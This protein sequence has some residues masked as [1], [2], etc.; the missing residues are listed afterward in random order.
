MDIRDIKDPGFLK[1]LSYK[2]MEELADQIRAFI[3]SEVSKTGG[4]LSSN[5]GVVELTIALHYVFNSPDDKLVFDVGHQTYTHKILTGRANGFDNLRQFGGLAGFEKRSESIHDVWEAG[6]S[7]TSLSGA[8]GMAVARDLKK[9]DHEVVAVIGDGSLFNGESMEALDHIAT[10]KSKVIIVLNDNSMSINR[11]DGAFYKTLSAIRTSYGYIDFKNMVA[12][13]LNNTETGSEVLKG[14]RQAR[15]SMRK[16]LAPDTIFKQ[17]GLD[18]LGPINGHDIE[19]LIKSFQMARRHK[20]SIVIHVITQKGKGYRFSENDEEGYWHGVGCF[21][22]VTGQSTTMIPDGCSTYSAVVAEKALTMADADPMICAITPAMINGSK[23]HKFH[24]RYPQRCFDCGIAEEH[25]ATFAAGLAISG[26][27]PMLFVYSSFMQRCYDQINH[28]ICRMDLPVLLLLDRAGLVGKDGATHHGVFDI[29]ILAPLPNIIL[30]MPAT[31]SEAR[32]L[33]DAAA[34]CSHPFAMRFPNGYADDDGKTDEPITIGTW[35]YTDIVEKRKPKAIVI[36]YG[37]DYGRIVNKAKANDLP[38][39]VVNARFFKPLDMEMIKD[40]FS[41]KVPVYVFGTDM[42]E[43]GLGSLILQ[44]CNAAGIP[45]SF[46]EY[47]IGDHYV[48][49]GSVVE[50]RKAEGIDINTIMDD[51]TADLKP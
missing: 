26:M 36:S 28:D 18:Y 47:G 20:G 15:D 35:S 22:P 16:I 51:I 13:R 6:H 44:H 11:N 31:P 24:Q 2:Q 49:H 50:L 4:H 3:V 1:T 43:G 38:I 30:S 48:E 7:S 40:I 8:L 9:E 27:K 10:T 5:L 17:M 29:G 12:G 32:A 41:R 21:D 34:G 25:A 23:L 42:R 39:K 33:M 46:T 37:P 19:A 14:M 45:A